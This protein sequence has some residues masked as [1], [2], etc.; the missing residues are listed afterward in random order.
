MSDFVRTP[1]VGSVKT[2]YVNFPINGTSFTETD[3][4][5]GTTACT[6]N[7]SGEIV[8]LDGARIVG[9]V[10]SISQDGTVASVLVSGVSEYVGYTT[11]NPIVGDV[12]KCDTTGKV[13][14]NTTAELNGRGFVIE[15]DSSNARC[16][17]LL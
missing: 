16:K 11:T 1:D 8:K 14:K 10:E 9:F 2:G 7:S 4:E 12:V 15:I 17:V 13:E 6:L 5:N 3:I